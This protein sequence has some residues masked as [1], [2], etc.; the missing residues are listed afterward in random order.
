MIMRKVFS[1]FFDWDENTVT[2]DYFNSNELSFY[3]L[4]LQI[5]LW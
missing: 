3:I 5:I 4:E 1:Q 2:I